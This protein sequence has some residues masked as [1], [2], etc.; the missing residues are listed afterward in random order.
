ME[1]RDRQQKAAG[2]RDAEAGNE[3]EAGRTSNS[4]DGKVRRTTMGRVLSL[5]VVLSLT[6]GV[7]AQSTNGSA[8]KPYVIAGVVRGLSATSLTLEIADRG[9]VVVGADSATR[10]IGRGMASDLLLRKGRPRLS[11]VIKTGDRVTVSCRRSGRKLFAVEIRVV[12][13]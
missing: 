3:T 12:Q 7:G 13:S 5:V 11:D 6:V 1:P 10:F 2:S 9:I 4:Q 8:P